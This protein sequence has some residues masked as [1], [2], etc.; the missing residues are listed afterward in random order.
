MRPV[1][2]AVL[3]GLAACESNT[4]I[5]PVNV[6]WMEW[7]AQVAADDPFRTRLVVW[8]PC[9]STKGF[10][11]SPTADESAVT[12][13]PYFV[14]SKDPVNCPDGGGF[15]TDVALSISLDTAG[16]APGLPAA[17]ERTYQM[18]SQ[19]PSCPACSVLNSLPWVVFGVVTVRPTLPPPNSVRNAAGIVMAQRDSVGCLRIRPSGLLGPRG[20]I[21]MENP[22]DTTSRWSGWTQGYI[23]EP[24]APV[25][26]EARAFHRN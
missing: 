17:A 1:T 20:A 21:V 19:G 16:M 25:C 22:P 14:T 7:P 26:G 2:F 18:R 13:S 24:G 11:P 23:Y 15:V 6:V 12:F 10:E 3:L 5:L 8:Q 9:A 4:S